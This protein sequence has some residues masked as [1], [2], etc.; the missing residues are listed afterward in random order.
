[1]VH[2]VMLAPVP[3]IISINAA[4]DACA[5]VTNGCPYRALRCLQTI[6]DTVERTVKSYMAQ[7]SH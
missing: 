5:V 1:M 6:V 4:R 7:Q 2:K 3:P